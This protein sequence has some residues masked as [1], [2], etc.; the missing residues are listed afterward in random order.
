[1][2]SLRAARSIPEIRSAMLEGMGFDPDENPEVFEE[3]RRANVRREERRTR[4]AALHRNTAMPSAVENEEQVEHDKRQRLLT[5][6]RQKRAD[7]VDLTGIETSVKNFCYDTKCEDCNSSLEFQSLCIQFMIECIAIRIK[8]TLIDNDAI[9]RYNIEPPLA[10]LIRRFVA[11]PV[12]VWLNEPDQV[13]SIGDRLEE[14]YQGHI[15]PLTHRPNPKDVRNEARSFRIHQKKI[16]S[17]LRHL[18]RCERE[19]PN[20]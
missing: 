12:N 9:N 18:Q 14:V 3:M 20:A 4:E 2:A 13:Y 5:E 6:L 15:E 8:I 11:D 17:L 10:G 19:T 7:G 1:M 16:R